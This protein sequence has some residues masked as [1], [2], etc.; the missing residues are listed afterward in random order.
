MKPQRLRS[1]LQL[2]LQPGLPQLGPAGPPLHLRSRT[3]PGSTASGG[4]GQLNPDGKCIINGPLL[5]GRIVTLSGQNGQRTASG[6][7]RIT[8]SKPPAQ[9]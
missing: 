8:R 9:L 4:L 7:R 6:I 2:L 1:V 5:I 3:G